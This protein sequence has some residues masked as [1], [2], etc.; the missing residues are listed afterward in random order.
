MGKNVRF[1]FVGVAVIL[2]SGCATTDTM[3]SIGSNLGSNVSSSITSLFNQRGSTLSAL[4]ESKKFREAD[5]YFAKERTYFRENKKENIPTLEKLRVGL[6][7]IWDPQIEPAISRITISKIA[8]PEN[9]GEAKNSLVAGNKTYTD[10]STV[11]I[12]KEPGFELKSAVALKAALSATENEWEKTSQDAFKNYDHLAG[13]SFFAKYPVELDVSF[14]DSNFS[15]TSQLVGSLTAEQLGVFATTYSTQ[16]SRSDPMTS[17]MTTHYLGKYLEKAPKPV[18]LVSVIDAIKRA[19]A[20]GFNPKT[21]PG[22]KIGFAE[23]TSQTLMKEGHIEF[24]AQVTMD[25]PFEPTKAEIDELLVG[26]DKTYPD[27]LIIIDVAKASTSRRILAKTDAG[28]RFVSGSRTEPNPAYEV[29]RGKL[30]E[31]RSGLARAQGTY[32]PSLAA[33]I[34]NGIAVGVWSSNVKNAEAALYST[35]PSVTSD[36][37]SEYKYNTSEVKP[38]RVMSTNYY[39]IDRATK[40]YYKGVFDAAESKTFKI[41][42]NLHDRDTQR[43][44]ILSQ[45]DKED[46]IANFEQEPMSVPAS[47]IVEDYLKNASSAKPLPT[48]TKLRQEILEDKNKALA[49]HKAK[50]FDGKP[51][52]DSRFDSVVVILSPKGVLGSGFFVKPTMVLTNYHVVEGVKFVEMKMY[53]GMETFGKVVKSDVR[54]DLALIK[55]QDQGVPVQFF[56]GNTIDLGSTLEAIGHPKGLTFSITRGIASAVR[57]KKSVYAVGGKDVMFV[58]TDAAINPGNSGG[59]LF[60]GQQVV[61]VNNNKLVSGSEGLGFAVHYSEVAEFMKES[62]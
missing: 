49:N 14:L 58:Q 31:A 37:T 2:L 34:I 53:N 16:I 21:V 17:L 59:P 46:D 20:A 9:W 26:Q 33:A 23:V 57:K 24:P 18:S 48:I 56:E 50:Q 42:Y 35:P 47:A 44:Q 28:S 1:T 40:K 8:R 55:V 43:H 30:Y 7:A 39:V 54:L 52:K 5:D 3:G 13:E 25:L 38:N 4:I 19:K 12:F 6:A 10:V 60:L 36:L 22:I 15:L 27:F 11:E 41:S 32:S 51:L 45:H 29:A 61:G 62:F